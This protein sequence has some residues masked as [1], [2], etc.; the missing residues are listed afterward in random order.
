MVGCSLVLP[1]SILYHLKKDRLGAVLG[2]AV[3]T[4]VLTVFGSLFN[5]VYLL[6]KFSQL[7]GLPLDTIIA[8]GTA[9]NGN[10]RSISTFVL[11]AVAPLNLIKGLSV[12]ILT[13]LIYKRIARP[14]LGK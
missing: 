11:L 3:G 1:A 14:L 7:F 2:L 9:I 12:S 6:P 13:L 10:I 8:M 5:A 4:V